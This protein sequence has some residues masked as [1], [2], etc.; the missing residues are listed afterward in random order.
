[1]LERG[2][3]GAFDEVDNEE[4]IDLVRGN[5]GFDEKC[6]EDIAGGGGDEEE[7]EVGVTAAAPLVSAS[8]T[9]SKWLVLDSRE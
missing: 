3:S 2:L 1:M 7:V 4:S 5:E 6:C 9:E 8:G